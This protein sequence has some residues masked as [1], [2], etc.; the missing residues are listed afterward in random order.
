[1]VRIR[2]HRPAQRVLR[3]LLRPFG[4]DERNWLRI[5]QIRSWTAFLEEIG[6]SDILEISPGWNSMW[7][8]LSSKSYRSV[9][10]PG[11]DI[12]RETLAERFDVVIAD[13]V[14]EHVGDPVAA[15]RNMRAMLRPGGWALVA[16]PFLFRI[17]A[18]PHDYCRWTE[19]GLRRLLVDGGFED[20]SVQTF[21]WGN[22][23]CVRAHLGGEVKPFGFGRS[24]R[25]EPEYPV[26]VWAFAQRTETQ[27]IE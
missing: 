8:K 20:R 17:H 15:V 18:R 27:P 11:F 10:F 1:M 26:M 24:L 7:E 5:A 9:D 3:R 25:N 21:S 13:Q 22:R 12:T 4:W 14:L 2:G 16:T 6:P 19:A 23:A